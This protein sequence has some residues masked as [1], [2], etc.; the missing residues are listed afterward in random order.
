MATKGKSVF[1]EAQNDKRRA[2]QSQPD[3]A[4]FETVLED[5]L[6]ILGELRKGISTDGHGSVYE[7]ARASNLAGL[8]FSGG[9]IRSATFNLGVIQGLARHCLL[10]RFDYLSTVSGGGYIGGWLSA[11][12]H[13]TAAPN[14]PIVD[15]QFVEDFQACLKT[16]PDDACACG[17]A[18]G[19]AGFAG[20]EAP[21]V[22]YLRRFS[23]YLSPMRG[24]SGD[25]M[26]VISIVL[27]NF[28][29]IQ[30]ALVSLLATLLLA[31][32]FYVVSLKTV[33]IHHA[34]WSFVWLGGAALAVA[35]WWAGKLLVKDRPNGDRVAEM[36]GRAAG[37]KRTV[38]A[39]G[40]AS[41][42]NSK[43]VLYAVVCPCFLAAGFLAAVAVDFPL[44]LVPDKEFNVGEMLRWVGISAVGYTGAWGLG[45][46]ASSPISRTFRWRTKRGAPEREPRS[47]GAEEPSRTA[48]V[49][50]PVVSGALFGALLYAAAR[51]A[52]STFTQ[53][54]DDIWHAIA[55]GPPVF[56]LGLSFV[57]TVHI[58]GAR[59][60]FSEDEREWLA[61]LGGTVLLG[62]VLWTLIFGLVLYAAP[63]VRWLAGVDVAAFLAWVGGS[64]FGAWLARDAATSGEPGGSRWKEAVLVV[65]PW[66]FVLGL[67]VIVAYATHVA[68]M[69]FLPG[70]YSYPP[71]S[72]FWITAPSAL[73]QLNSLPWTKTAIFLLSALALF[74]ITVRRL[75]INLFSLHAMYSNRLARAYLGASRS[76][77]S[78][79]RHPYSGFDPED[80]LDFTKCGDQRPIHV[81]NTAV[82]LTGSDDLAWQT[83]RSASFTFTP[84]WAGYETRGSLGKTLG[85]Y[86]PSGGYAGNRKLGTLMAIS[87]AAASPNMGYHTSAPVAALMTAFNLRLGRWCGNPTREM[88]K[89]ISPKYAWRPIRAELSG[90]ATVS[91]DWINLTDGGHFENLGVYEL[92]RRRCRLI[93]VTDA[94]CDPRH[95]FEDLGNLVRKCWTDFGVNIRFDELEPVRLQDGSRYCSA[96]GTVG[97]IQY[98]DGGDDGAI[99]YLKCSMTGDEWVDIRQYAESHPAFPHESTADQFF[100][101]TQFEAYRHLGYKVVA[102]MCKD[103]NGFL[104]E[105]VNEFSI[106]DLVARLIQRKSPERPCAPHFWT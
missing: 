105:D 44:G 82:N 54:A 58:G 102:K 15:E 5:E 37:A 53:Q 66:F 41:D 51:L 18:V 84:R 93:V 8:A 91:S 63:F 92:V 30:L 60:A 14:R 24:V 40:D 7:R 90:S 64:G 28:T 59:R 56:L 70:G 39:P 45:Y 79:R 20:V 34:S 50:A 55:F 38:D 86:R 83:R 2:Q 96:H 49:L 36:G 33:V 76:A 35:V 94:G 11:L 29:L 57:V 73:A 99:I 62:T 17:E 104:G 23:S 32:H 85:C 69:T 19:T 48:L 88:W 75:D 100:D 43:W 52:T 27:R 72:D 89:E 12:L 61:R 42:D 6:G 103:L 71:Y 22:R 13:R 78:R 74:W 106:E 10:S 46:F 4:S 21:A 47:T 9:G 80:D 67:A 98:H 31:A 95:E 16:H 77:K 81:V 97:R 101:E 1:P 26:A 65:A 68:L 3:N 87:G 25:M